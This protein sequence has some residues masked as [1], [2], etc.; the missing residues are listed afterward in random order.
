MIRVLY[1]LLSILSL[2]SAASRGP[3]ALVGNRARR[4]GMK[5]L[6]KLI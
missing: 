2:L 5:G 3:G 1:K 6:R 4:A